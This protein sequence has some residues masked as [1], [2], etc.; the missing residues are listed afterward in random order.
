MTPT[1]ILSDRML[2]TFPLSDRMMSTSILNDRKPPTFIL[3][4]RMPMPAQNFYRCATPTLIYVFH[5]LCEVFYTAWE[6]MMINRLTSTS[7]PTHGRLQVRPPLP[8]VIYESQRQNDGRVI[9][10]VADARSKQ[11]P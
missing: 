10:A 6:I 1:S 7:P 5:I 11:K 4:D 3:S 9:D 8:G 2:S